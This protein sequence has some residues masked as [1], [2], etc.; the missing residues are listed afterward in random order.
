MWVRALWLVIF[1][2][3]DLGSL[4]VHVCCYGV[5]LDSMESCSWPNGY[6]CCRD[7]RGCLGQFCKAHLSLFWRPLV[8]VVESLWLVVLSRDSSESRARVWLGKPTRIWTL[9]VFIIPCYCL[10]TWYWFWHLLIFRPN[11]CGVEII[12][13]LDNGLW[14]IEKLLS[15]GYVGTDCETVT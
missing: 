6:W 7:P 3:F 2:I 13:G 1:L 5:W 9:F 14:Y 4:V 12:F 8:L 15:S 11:A 10:L